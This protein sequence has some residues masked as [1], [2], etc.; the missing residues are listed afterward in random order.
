MSD[1]LSQVLS[2]APRR[3]TLSLLGALAASIALAT[4]A[5]ADATPVQ[6]VLQYVPGVSTTETRSATGIAELVL[7]EGEVRITAADLPHLDDDQ[8]YTA[9]LLNTETNAYERI[10]HFNADPE[11]GKVRYENVL[12]DAI[13]DKHWNLLLI[14]VEDGLDATSPGPDHSLAGLFRPR[15]SDPLPAVLPNTGGLEDDASVAPQNRPDWLAQSGLAALTTVFGFGAG[16]GVGA[17][18]RAR[19]RG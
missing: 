5:L 17:R 15:E 1:V 8:H 3:A 12:P 14:T 18:R 6:L 10:G 11:S 4:A 19:Q 2:A 9:W 7:P 13:P 16:Y